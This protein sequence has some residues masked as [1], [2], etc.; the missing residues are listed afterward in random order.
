VTVSEVV[1]W[2]RELRPAVVALDSPRSCARPGKSSRDGE[3]DLNR[4]I[5]GIRWT[6]EQSRLESNPYYEWIVHGLELYAALSPNRGRQRWKVIEVF[7]TASW[8]VWADPKGKKSRAQWTRE[9]LEQLALTR[10]PPR[11]L[12]QDD[13]DALAA[14]VT[15]RLHAD[16]KTKSFGEIVVPERALPVTESR[17]PEDRDDALKL[18]LTPGSLRCRAH[19]SARH[20]TDNSSHGQSLGAAEFHRRAAQQS[21]DPV[22]RARCSRGLP[23]PS[24]RGLGN[25][26]PPVGAKAYL[27]AGCGA[28]GFSWGGML[29]GL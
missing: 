20:D 18:V 14:A 1:A 2:M 15:A 19:L 28:T 3:R 27:L 12:T 11:R 25:D 26:D 4:A 21:A 17:H 7:P 13:R 5:C 22:R 23:A 8:T 24:L 16:K 6:P 29:P 9:A 10:L